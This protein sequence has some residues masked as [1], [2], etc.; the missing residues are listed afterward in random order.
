MFSP[1]SYSIDKEFISVYFLFFKKKI[2]RKDIVEIKTLE[3]KEVKFSIRTFGIGGFFGYI[4]FFYNSKFGNMRWFAT[5]RNYFILI[6]TNN[7]KK[8]VISPKL[9]DKFVSF[10]NE[11]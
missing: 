8:I 11:T 7:R 4:G 5:N 2:P 1:I 6:S 9:K 3:S 10:F